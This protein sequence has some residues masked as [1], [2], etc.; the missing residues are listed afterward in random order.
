MDNYVNKDIKKEIEKAKRKII[1]ILISILGIFII[2]A[3]A[4][5]SVY[6]GIF[7]KA[8][9]MDYPDYSLIESITVSKYGEPI[10][11]SNEECKDL[12]KYISTAK[13]TRIMS[14]NETPDVTPF[15][16]VEIKTKDSLIYWYGYIYQQNEKFYFEIPYVG[17]YKFQI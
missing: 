1:S 17:V 13:P 16:A 10:Y 8:K 12:Y 3:V 6:N 11:L 7:P 4:V 2:C 14:S 5:Y 15:Y 9:E